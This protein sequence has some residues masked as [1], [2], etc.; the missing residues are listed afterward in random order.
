MAWRFARLKLRLL[1]NGLLR[2]PKR[3]PLVIIAALIPLPIAATMFAAIADASNQPHPSTIV[4]L[5]CGTIMLAWITVPVLGYGN[6][7][8]LDPTIFALF[9][10]TTGQ[11]M[12]GML[13]AAVVG[14]GPL[15]TVFALSGTLVAFVSD[16]P[17]LLASVALIAVQLLSAVTLSRAITTSLGS[18]L[19]SR[20]G[21]DIAMLITVALL[22]VAELL[23]T[24]LQRNLGAK[25]SNTFDRLAG[26]AR[27]SPPGI[28]GRAFA[29]LA[30]HDWALVAVAL[31]VHAGIIVVSVVLWTRALARTVDRPMVA[32]KTASH[33]HP[34]ERARARSARSIFV[35]MNFL[36]K[37]RT[38]AVAARELRAFRRDPRRAAMLIP[39]IT[40]PI[41]W[42]LSLRPSGAKL[43]DG[44]PLFA[45][46]GIVFTNRYSANLLGVDGSAYW[47]HIVEGSAP[48]SDLVGKQLAI[49][50]VITPLVI[51]LAMGF[52][53][54]AGAYAAALLTILLIPTVLGI[55]LGIGVISSAR[56]PQAIPERGNPFGTMNGQGCANGI[57]A[58]V[59]LMIEL[60]LLLPVGIALILA[61]RFQIVVVPVILALSYAMGWFIWRTATR[62]ASE[63][64]APRL[65]EL[66]ALIDAKQA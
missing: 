63:Y 30:T 36:P 25:S 16:V 65:P 40:V 46:A 17:T 31:A 19:A 50:L 37:N 10:F 12:R 42:A 20:R 48:Y 41:V 44:I 43:S 49:S 35:H 29:G 14:I 61:I 64:L 6:D 59:M 32:P 1:R 38:G 24:Q 4:T 15:F 33:R 57:A 58:V 51:V 18:M 55:H 34:S 47:P 54:V 66:L 5:A 22:V 27:W 13:A 52:G 8:T 53:V 7:D 3:L 62:Y 60:L 56:F 11:L 21:R 39:A 28:V 26:F 9:P 45:L 23:N 2:N